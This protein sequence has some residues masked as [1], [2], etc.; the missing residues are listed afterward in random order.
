MITIV[1]HQNKEFKIDLSQPLDISI[2][3]TNTNENPIAWYQNKP[4][5][6]PVTMGDW[7]GKVSEGKSSTNFNNI[8]FNPHAHGTHTECLGHITRDFYSINQCLKQFFFT[9]EV[10]S[11]QPEVLGEDLIITKKQIETALDSRASLGMTV[12]AIIIRTLPN[13]KVKL[14][15][16]YSNTNPP[17]L[18]EDAATFIRESAIQHLLIDLPS[19]DREHDE[20]KL[21]AHK[22]F[23]N[24]KNVNQL[25]ADARMHCT[26][27]EMVFVADT[28]QDGSY[29]LNL[30]IASFENDASPSKPVLYKIL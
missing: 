14:S 28:I 8:F 29:I 26:I 4:D 13:D 24:V 5:I 12:E 11:V 15:K 30:Q 18:T 20:G 27:T 21:L 1:N 6:E 23:W 9:A 3:L 2:P 17:Y 25:N 10:I 19:V 22:A 16:N 7:I